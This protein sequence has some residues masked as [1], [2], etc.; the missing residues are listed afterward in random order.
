MKHRV[1]SCTDSMYFP[2]IIHVPQG[3]WAGGTH[4]LR[5]FEVNTKRNFENIL[6]NEQIL[7][8]VGISQDFAP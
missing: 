2:W 8:S 4:N 1:K 3:D 7:P 5:H 6:Q